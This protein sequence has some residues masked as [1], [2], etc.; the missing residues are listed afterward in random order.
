M[1]AGI[2]L[3]FQH[4]APAVRRRD[5]RQFLRRITQEVAGRSGVTCLITTD[6]ELRRLNRQF[7]GKDYATDV[8]SFPAESNAAGGSSG[9]LGEIAISYDR[10]A[11][12]AATL[13]H[14]V[15]QELRIL[16]LHAVLH[17]AGMDHETDHGRMRREEARW[18]RHFQLPAGLIERANA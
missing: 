2:E 4:S 10:A 13:G 16:M 5:L 14:G 6:Q 18:R 11:E 12:Q 17:L 7:L 15:E 8:L 3:V 9:P 1:T